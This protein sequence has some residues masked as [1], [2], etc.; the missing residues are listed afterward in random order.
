M[1]R[2][3]FSCQFDSSLFLI[4]FLCDPVTPSSVPL[5]EYIFYNTYY[6]NDPESKNIIRIK[7]ITNKF[8][9][10]FGQQGYKTKMVQP[11]TPEVTKYFDKIH[12]K[13]SG[14]SGGGWMGIKEKQT[15]IMIESLE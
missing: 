3:L 13:V 14:N 7:T 6:I 11:R 12:E 9:E 2:E 4:P 15:D 1:G 8:I 10:W 5:I